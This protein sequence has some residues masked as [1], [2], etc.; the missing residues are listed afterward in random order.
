MGALREAVQSAVK[1]DPLGYINFKF[2][3]SWRNVL[4]EMLRS[5]EASLNLDDVNDIA[6]KCFADTNDV[7]KMLK[8]FH[9]LG[10]LVY[11]GDNPA[12]SDVVTL[13]PQWLV[14][15]ISL[16]IRDY[17][18]HENNFKQRNAAHNMRKS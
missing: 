6:K 3:I 16:V 7:P 17:D 11:F 18:E 4:D 5:D 1:D 2:P 14:D 12:L 13:R 10:T 8:L 9:E 15:A